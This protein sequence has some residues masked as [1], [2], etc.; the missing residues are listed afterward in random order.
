M[1]VKKLFTKKTLAI[2]VTGALYNI[3]LPASAQSETK[4]DKNVEYVEVKGIRRS[5]FLSGSIKRESSG[6][7]DAITAEDIGKFPDTNLAESLQRI[8]GVSI[9]RSNNEGNQVT[10]RGFGPSFN[11][12]TLNGRQMPRSSSLTSDGIPRSFNFRELSSE[13]VSEIQ[14]YK[15]AR[16]N[17]D[18]GG[19]GATINIETAK[20]FDY[21]GFKAYGSVKGIIDTSVESGDT[22]T[23]ELSGA[24]SNTFLDGK[25]GVLLSLGHSVRHSHTDRAGTEGWVR[26]HGQ[27]INTSQINNGTGAWWAAQTVDLDLIDTERERQNAQLVVQFAPNENVVAT[28]DYTLQRF[29]QKSQMNRQGMWFDSP[30]GTPDVNGTLVNPIEVT[31]ELNFWAWQFLEQTEGDSLGLNIEWQVNDSLSFNV[32]L[33]GAESKSNPNGINS[34]H[35]ANLANGAYQLNDSGDLVAVATKLVDIT[36]DFS[37]DIPRVVVDDS[38]LP[39]GNAYDPSNIIPDLFHTFGYEIDN[40]IQQNR[41][42]GKWE[43]NNSGALVEVNFG[44]QNTQYEVDTRRFG[45]FSFVTSLN[46]DNL[47]L[48]FEDVGDA[49]SEFGGAQSLY[50]LVPRYSADRFIQLAEEQGLFFQVPPSQ[51]GVEEKTTAAFVSAD[52]E[53]ELAGMQTYANIGLRHEQTDV[54]AYSVL[55]S[56]QNLQYN[57][58][59]G[60]QQVPDG[61]PVAQTLKGEYNNTLPNLDVKLDLT[62]KLVGR[63]SYGKSITRSD[64]DKMFPSTR[65]TQLRPNEVA[66]ARQG[67]PNLLPY[68]SDNIDISFEYYYGDASYVSMGYFHKDVDNFIGEITVN[69]TLDDVNGNPLTNP[70]VNADPDLCPSAVVPDPACFNRADQPAIEFEFTTPSNLDSSEVDGW[71]F[72][73]QHVFGESGFGTIANYTVVNSDAE[74]DIR[75]IDGNRALTGLS[76]SAN[77]V[78]F[79]EKGDV[80]V[81]IAYNWRDQF[82][83]QGGNEPTFTEDYGQLDANASYQVNEHFTVFVEGLNLTNATIRRHGRYQQ[84]LIDAEQYGSRFNVGVRATF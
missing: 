31:D 76:D 51:D 15:T 10:V 67:N 25:L 6:V 32:D 63:F 48:T 43:N 79:Y 56:I 81:R 70:S 37:T 24:I 78:G 69:R 58:V 60:I 49:L 53:F 16:A 84:Q 68:V 46:I 12:V 38:A 5:L 83:L 34:E 57:H 21:D 4:A 42:T 61:V 17:V 50:P 35:R 11:M 7:V 71:E 44:L 23:P 40:N 39:G 64:L 19:I 77:F 82:L 65:I 45:T 41:I 74:Y 13:S 8:T 30:T 36:A 14:V 28:L 80:L 2:A 66:K 22:V 18:S 3:A 52:F 33:H 55:E 73:L 54:S 59:T 75:K 47:G 20:P 1:P 72:T 62:D 26:N 29:E 27:N 9:D